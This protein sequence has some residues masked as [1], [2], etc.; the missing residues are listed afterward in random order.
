MRALAI[1][2]RAERLFRRNP[3][4]TLAALWLLVIVIMGLVALLSRYDPITDVHVGQAELGPGPGHWLGTDH[5]GRDVLKRLALACQFF[6]APGMLACLVS[7]AI[8]IPAG[9]IAGFEGGWIEAGIRWVFT[10]VASVPRFVLL[11]LVLSIYGDRLYLLAIAAG[12]AYA[13]TLAE[14]VFG[15]IEG[16]RSAEYVLANRAYGVPSWRI[17]WVHLVWAASRRLVARHLVTLFG[18]YL[19]LETTLSYIGGFGVQEPMPS[20]GN[21]LAFDW[22]YSA[23][24]APQVLAPVV[25]LW[26]TIVAIA[27][28]AETLG[29]EVADA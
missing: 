2:R 14:A 29:G 21:M 6:V 24:Y 25:V 26:V 22:G 17:L 13:P 3:A 10:V 27:W 19:V 23:W 12:V 28:V 1:P 16:L 18:Y 20:W 9:A 8:A 4:A 11:L 5:L 7:A 15:R